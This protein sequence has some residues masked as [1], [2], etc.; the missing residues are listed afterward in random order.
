MIAGIVACNYLSS[1]PPYPPVPVGPD[2]IVFYVTAGNAPTTDLES[3]GYSDIVGQGDGTLE[4]AQITAQFRGV[5]V[6]YTVRRFIEYTT[7]NTPPLIGR[8]LALTLLPPLP[9]SIPPDVNQR[10][11]KL[12]RRSDAVLLASGTLT[13]TQET[14]P[15]RV[16]VVGEEYVFVLTVLPH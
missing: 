1:E 3:V 4:P 8:F 12:Y 6:N 15:S 2:D 14:V 10:P 5:T 9:G 16:L 13:G 7:L 11:Y